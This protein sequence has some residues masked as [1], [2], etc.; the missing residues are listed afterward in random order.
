MAGLLVVLTVMYNGFST[1]LRHYQPLPL[2]PRY[3]YPISVPAV[4]LTGGLLSSLL[5]SIDLRRL[6]RERAESTFWGG[7]VVFMLAGIIA[8]STF[9]LIRD[10]YGKPRWS[11]AEKYLAGVVSPTDRIHTDAL[12]RNSLEFF[13]RYPDKMNVFVY[14]EPGHSDTIQC[15]D[16]VLRNRSYDDWLTSRPGMWLTM[17]GFETP[18]AVQ[19]PPANWRVQW[20]DENATLFK[21]ACNE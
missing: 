18:S 8:S 1:S 6:L 14:G 11:S 17:R 20:T 15:G 13:W 2:F 12:S 5:P 4:I 3:F 9:R 16:Y 7:I 21:V 10:N 19:N